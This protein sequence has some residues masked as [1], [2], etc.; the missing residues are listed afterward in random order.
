D[1]A[2]GRDVTILEWP[3]LSTPFD[4]IRKGVWWAAVTMAASG[5]LGA[6]L[7]RLSSQERPAGAPAPRS[8]AAGIVDAHQRTY[9]VLGNNE[10][11]S[12]GAARGE[13]IYFYKCW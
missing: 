10:V 4:T 7:A 12:S 11:A 1:R 9:E 2:R 6:G 3:M 8:A 5:A 13:T